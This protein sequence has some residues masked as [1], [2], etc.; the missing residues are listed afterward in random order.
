MRTM[1]RRLP[2][3]MAFL[4]LLCGA[5]A[6][7]A[8]A[9][10]HMWIKAEATV[11][12]DNG[13]FIGLSYRW[14]FDED[15]T[16]TAIEGLDKNKDGIYDREELAELAKVNM[17]GLKEYAYFTHA[18]V[19]GQKLAMGDARDYWLEHKGALLALHFT[20]PFAAPV[21]ADAKG[22]SF[23]VYDPEFFIAFELEGAE[24]VMLGAGAPKGCIVRLAEPAQKPGD[25]TALGELQAQMGAFADGLK[26]ISVE[27]RGP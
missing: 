17:E 14:I 9:H 8:N 16:A 15:Y 13:A 22:F 7:A 11:L 26:M 21:P 23:A 19:A 4:A 2:L 12:H 1:R 6:S 27:C 20:L 18:F 25:G 24:A 10:P 5:L 3:G